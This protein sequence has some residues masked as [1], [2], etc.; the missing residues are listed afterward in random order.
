M[1]IEPFDAMRNR[2]LGSLIVD[3]PA[4]QIIGDASVEIT[5][6]A[7]DSRTV[8]PGD[9]FVALVGGYFDGHAFVNRA[10]ARGAAAIMVERDL[11]VEVPRVMVPNTR[12]ALAPVSAEFFGH[13]SRTLPVIGITGTDGK[14]TTSHLI[15]AIFTHAGLTCGMIG[16]IGV[17]IGDRP[18]SSESRQTTPESL[19]MQRLMR[20]M[21]DEGVDVAIVEATSHGLDLHRLDATV[22]RAAAVTSITHEHLEHH[23][24]VEAYRRAKARLFEA[25]NASNGHSVINIDDP[26]A[27]EMLGYVQADATTT[28][29]AEGSSA[30]LVASDIDLTVDG[31][32]FNLRWQDETVTVETPLLGQ[33]N[34][35]NALC[36]LG[37]ALSHQVPLQLAVDALTRVSPIPGR[38]Q[39]IRRGQPFTVIVDYAHTPDSIEKVLTLVRKLNPRGRLIVVMGSAGE[40]DRTKRPLQGEVAVRLADFSFFTTEDPRFEDPDAIIDEIAEGARRHGAREG[41]DFTC[42]TDRREAIDRAFRMARPGDCVLLTGKGHEQSIIWGLEKRPWDEV[43]VATELLDA[44]GYVGATP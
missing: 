14:T 38:M 3:V 7:I 41:I 17:R 37:V 31:S 21:L 24:T 13:P 23:K 9:L 43:A 19:D 22:F 27:R 33:F 44:L 36:A 35:A 20:T 32:R 42:V 4:A 39:A 16:T 6:I 2:S 11:P 40:R 15:E 34:V 1:R 28:Y 25:V 8:S 10:I 26:G 18:L 5:G 29:S 12:A 30:D